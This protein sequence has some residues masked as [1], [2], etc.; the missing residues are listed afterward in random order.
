MPASIA[1]ASWQGP[2]RIAA[3]WGSFVM[4]FPR[5]WGTPKLPQIN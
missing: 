2:T 1:L 3:D 5:I 4:V